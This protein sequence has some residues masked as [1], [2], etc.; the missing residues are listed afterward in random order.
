METAKGDRSPSSEVYALPE[1]GNERRVT[2]PEAD[3]MPPR[4]ADMQQ[5]MTDEKPTLNKM[6]PLRDDVIWDRLANP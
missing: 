2:N 5:Y 1:N 6:V 3:N 4:N